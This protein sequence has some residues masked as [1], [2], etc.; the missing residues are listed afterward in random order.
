[1]DAVLILRLALLACSVVFLYF[2]ITDCLKHKEDFTS[3]K[4]VSLILVG[5]ITDFFDT[6]GIGCFATT[7][8]GFKFT[9]SCEDELM[10]GT[11]NVAHTLP[12]IA[13]ALLF[14][15]LVEIDTITLVGMIG[16]AALGAVIGAGIVSKWSVKFI[17]IALGCALTTVACIMIAQLLELGIFAGSSGDALSLTGVKLVLGLAINFLL[18][19]LMTVGVGLYAPCMALVGALGMNVSAA[20]PIMMGS[21]AFLMP[22]ASIRFIKEG[23]YDRKA[24]AIVNV[25]GVIGVL[26][27]Y[28][29]VKS[30]PLQTLKW[31][32]IA[33]MFYTAATFFRDANKV[34]TEE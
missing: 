25:A 26:V 4:A 5:F 22:A 31:I 15:G 29:F 11:L 17:R 32:V 9:K 10:P 21:C 27:A 28:Y 23:K 20:F 3:G 33:V 2:F 34:S 7:Q 24:A 19:A 16:M 8:T 6:L 30:L 18:G 12:I 1:M 14:L 13:E